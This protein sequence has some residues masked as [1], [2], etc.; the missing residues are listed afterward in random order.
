MSMEAG[1]LVVRIV[2]GPGGT[3]DRDIEQQVNGAADRAVK[4][5]GR[6]MQQIGQNARDMGAKMSLAATLPLAAVAKK[7]IE[8]SS[9]TIEATNKVNVVFGKSADE[10]QRFAD[11]SAKAFG[12]SRREA[13]EASGVFGNLFRAMGVGQGEAAKVSTAMTGL[14]GD[15]ASFNDADPTEVLDAL[16]AGLIGEAEPMRRFGVQLSEA[17]VQAE[18]F[19]LGIAK[20]VKNAAQITKANLAVEDSVAKL[21]QAQQTHGMDSREAEAAAA[22]LQLAQ[23]KLA[24]AM[25]G[26]KA[27]LTDRQKLMARESIIMKDTALAQGD[28]QRSLSDSAANQQRVTKALADDASAAIGTQILPLWNRV[29]IAAGEAAEAFGNLSPEAQKTV[30]I[31]GGV[32][33]AAGPL[34]TIFG[35]LVR[36]GGGVGKGLSMGAKAAKGTVDAAKRM[37]Q[38]YRDAQAAQSAFSGK[39]GTIG[40]K[41]KSTQTAMVNGAK[42]AATWAANMVKAALRATAALAKAAAQQIAH[43]A[44][45]AAAYAVQGA[46]M[47]A[48]MVATAARTAAAWAM[49]AARALASAARFALSWII[50]M[51]PIALVIAAVVA[52]A[53]VIYKNWDKIK[54][55]TV[56]VF[57]AVAGFVANA[58]GRIKAAVS[59]GVAA[60]VGFVRNNW[61]LL[62]A[63]VLGPLGIIIGLVTKHWSK[64]KATTAAAFNAVRNTVAKVIGAVVGVIRAGV[65]N[66]VTNFNRA[67]AL[68]VA[69]ANAVRSLVTGAFNA[70]VGAVSGAIGRVISTASSI[71]GKILSA[72]GGAASWLVQKGRDIVQGLINGVTGMFDSVMAKARELGDKVKGAFSGVLGIFSPSRVFAQ[73]GKYVVQGLIKGL[74]GSAK[75]AAKASEKLADMVQDAYDKR[76]KSRATK[77]NPNGYL[78]KQEK[79]QRKAVLELIKSQRKQQQALAK[80]HARILTDL[81][82]AREKLA[83]LRNQSKQYAADVAKSMVD[84][85]NIT[86]AMPEGV[87]VTVQSLTDRMR[88]QLQDAKGWAANLAKLTELGLNDTMLDQLVQAGVEGSAL[89][90]QE[91]AAATPQQIAELNRIQAELAKQGAKVGKS[92]ADELYGAGIKAAQAQ[93]AELE[94]QAGRIERMM[95]IQA[96]KF[97]NA[98]RKGL[99]LALH[100]FNGKAKGLY[101]TPADAKKKPAPKNIAGPVQTQRVQVGA[102]E[103]LR[104][105]NVQ[106]T[107]PKP[108]PASESV[109][110]RLRRLQQT[111]VI[112]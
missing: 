88:K 26:T 23:D 101:G 95:L 14:A 15:L 78:T 84:A 97:A 49:M 103:S 46:K 31:L 106:V 65:A 50:A 29:V 81:T 52:L 64:I 38:G 33:L 60:V 62:I 19:A 100:D 55:A 77:K 83:D 36:L 63:I 105:I 30:V 4:S 11:T 25:E 112:R 73:L 22:D 110:K 6:S 85:A 109:T 69:A 44:R 71:K 21:A 86:Q 47:V 59:A 10:V 13:L 82:A 41:I 39:A 70:L 40:G 96:Q 68:I 66:W 51:G 87:A 43:L 56:A 67:R 54:A 18:A 37:A 42:A 7:A 1:E 90:A 108:E 34:L 48:S 92:A 32:A 16:R 98:V 20:P 76:A 102:A 74:T 27:P 2:A 17:R 53:V 58:W 91:L 72:L 8:A 93:V 104:P 99:G 79:A 57:G 61:R 107:N 28:F 9:S 94:K 24:K 12:I 5:S 35:N 80:Q 111:G 75:D 3:L 45:I 89:V